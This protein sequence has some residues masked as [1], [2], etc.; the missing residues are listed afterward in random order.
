MA[1]SYTPRMGV[2]RWTDNGDTFT[3]DELDQSFVNIEAR[4]AIFGNGTLAAR[5]AA[6]VQGR[7]YL[8]DATEPD[9]AQRG[10]MYYDTGTAWVMVKFDLTAILATK[11][12]AS[13]SHAIGDLPA[14]NNGEV[15]GT[16]FVKA[17]DARLSSEWVAGDIL[18]SAADTRVGFLKMDGAQY[19]TADQPGLFA[20]IGYTYGGSGGVFNVPNINDRFPIGAQAGVKVLGTSGGS[21]LKTL[22]A[23]NIP[24]HLHSMAHTHAIDHTHAAA[25]T[26]ND[27]PDHAH[28]YDTGSSGGH[29]HNYSYRDANRVVTGGGA[30][31]VA[32]SASGVYSTSGGGGHS[33][34][35]NTNGASARHQHSIPALGYSG[36][37]GA[38]SA[39]NTGS[40]GSGTAF[41]ITPP[42]L[43]LNC[44]IKT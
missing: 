38:S 12:N 4:A 7:F 29:E 13:H 42:W 6:G 17:D 30:A 44:F 24:S 9:A 28:Y 2:R 22:A 18:W 11:A 31:T 15:S 25:T 37:S 39:G 16:K 21:W 23:G 5:P 26:G 19:N 27:S 43:A 36:A 3:R 40:T 14:A 20:K 1:E 35:G 41:D 32:D 34:A 33:H 10:Q 8:L